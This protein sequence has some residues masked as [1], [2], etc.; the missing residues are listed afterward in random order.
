MSC[1]CS[2][3]GAY[4]RYDMLAVHFLVVQL[5]LVVHLFGS[6]AWV[7]WLDL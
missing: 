6:G 4:I 7:G 3:V 1:C 5:M 2:H